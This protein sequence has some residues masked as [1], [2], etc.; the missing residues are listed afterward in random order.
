MFSRMT[1]SKKW[2]P[3]RGRSKTC[4]R[5][6]SACRMDSCGLKRARVVLE[7]AA[8][9]AGDGGAVLLLHAAHHHAG[10]AGLHDHGDA[11]GAQVRHQGVGHLAGQAL[12]HL[13]AAG[14]DIDHAGDLAQAHHLAVGQVAD[15]GVAEEGQHVVLAQRVEL[16][17]ADDHHLFD[18]FFEDAF[19][20]IS[21]A[22]S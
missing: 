12:L 1:S 16:D 14:E 21:S 8:H 10:V 22:D 15:V 4:V 19:L 9:G 3:D 7:G 11:V 13:Q 5:A 18:V 2:R 20:M 6:N 17:V